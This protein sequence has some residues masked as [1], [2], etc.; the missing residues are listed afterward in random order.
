MELKFKDF[1][2]FRLFKKKKRKRKNI[3]INYKLKLFFINKRIY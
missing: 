1:Q 2:I 3:K